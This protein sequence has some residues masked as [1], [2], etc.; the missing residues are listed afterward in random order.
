MNTIKLLIA[1]SNKHKIREIQEILSGISFH[2]VTLKDIGFAV[3]IKE[4]GKSFAENAIIK[5][6]AVGEVT[7]HLILAEDSGLEVD[8]L[9][10]RPG[11][12]SARYEKGSD[13]DRINKVLKDLKG[14]P[15]EKRTARF[16]AIVAVY[17]PLTD[18]IHTFEGVNE[19]YIT[20]KPLGKNGFGYDPI[21]FNFNLGKTNAQAVPEEK[22]RISHRAI[23]LIRIKNYLLKKVRA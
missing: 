11:I 3:D 4:T 17:D 16:R 13:A 8:M 5:A 7:R 6:K 12:Y 23:A 21:F 22:N 9:G 14:I 1:T 18:E 2:L 15:K 20:D 10:G 19:G